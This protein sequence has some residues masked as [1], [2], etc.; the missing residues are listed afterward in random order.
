M[1]SASTTRWLLALLRGPRAQLPTEGRTL[2]QTHQTVWLNLLTGLTLYHDNAVPMTKT[3]KNGVRTE[4]A[5]MN[6][7]RSADVSIVPSA[8]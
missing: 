1:W 7:C 8:V 3:N 4:S 6:E 5:T 2:A